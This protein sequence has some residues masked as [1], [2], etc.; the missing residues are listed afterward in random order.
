VLIKQQ[1][2][3]CKQA[4]HYEQEQEQEQEQEFYFL[5]RPLALGRAGT[6]TSSIYGYYSK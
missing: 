2:H 6:V 5:F 4:E 3:D 1:Y